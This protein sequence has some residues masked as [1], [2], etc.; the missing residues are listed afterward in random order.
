MLLR[1]VWGFVEF[2]GKLDEMEERRRKQTQM[3]KGRKDN[4][5]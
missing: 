2:A 3:T 1:D 5:N 4:G